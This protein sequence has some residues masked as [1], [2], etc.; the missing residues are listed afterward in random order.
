MLSDRLV[1]SETFMISLL[2]TVLVRNLTT[3]CMFRDTKWDVIFMEKADSCWRCEQK[4]FYW[5]KHWAVTIQGRGFQK[6]MTRNRPCRP[7]LSIYSPDFWSWWEAGTWR[8]WWWRRRWRSETPRPSPPLHSD[9][10]VKERKRCPSSK[11]VMKDN[12]ASED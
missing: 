10:S 9:C 8:R 4:N 11:H 6:S 2:R 12:S 7:R 5:N 1:W 3:V